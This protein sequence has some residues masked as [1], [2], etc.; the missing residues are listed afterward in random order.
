VFQYERVTVHTAVSFINFL[1]VAFGSDRKLTVGCFFLIQAEQRSRNG[2][3]N[4]STQICLLT[5]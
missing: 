1:Q 5:S 3:R 4:N 2:I